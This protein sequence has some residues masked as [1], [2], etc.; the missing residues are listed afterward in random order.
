[1]IQAIRNLSNIFPWRKTQGGVTKPVT[2]LARRF[3]TKMLKISQFSM[4]SLLVGQDALNTV[5]CENW[6]RKWK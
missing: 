1:M 5:G 3:Q 6:L 4:N 2:L